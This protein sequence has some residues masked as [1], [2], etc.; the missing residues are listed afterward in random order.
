MTEQGRAHPLARE[1]PTPDY[2]SYP[3]SALASASLTAHGTAA[4]TWPDGTTLECHPVWLRENAPGPGG[5]D[6]VTRE[7]DLDP[8]HLARQPV[9][10]S[11]G[12]GRR[13]ARGDV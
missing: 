8:A 1:L 12:R 6:P 5:I 11:I 9:H 10:Q 4:L 13:C 3:W 7:C 2:Y